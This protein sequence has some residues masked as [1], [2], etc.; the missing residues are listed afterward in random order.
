MTAMCKHWEAIRL[1]MTI[2][3]IGIQKLQHVMISRPVQIFLMP[4]QYTIVRQMVY[5][6]QSRAR[7]QQPKVVQVQ[8]LKA[9]QKQ[10]LPLLR[11]QVL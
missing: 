1:T 3:I 6:R 10:V 9:Q 5:H 2:K 7:F 11:E 4:Q 8:R